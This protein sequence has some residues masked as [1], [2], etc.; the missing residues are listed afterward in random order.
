MSQP[1]ELRV[2]ASGGYVPGDLLLCG[3]KAVIAAIPLYALIR[4]LGADRSTFRGKEQLA[5]ILC[6][7]V[8]TLR[9]HA[10]ALES[11]GWLTREVWLDKNTRQNR[12]RWTVHERVHTGGGYSVSRWSRGPSSGAKGLSHEWEG[13]IAP[14]SA[15]HP[16]V[17]PPS[18]KNTNGQQPSADAL[19]DVWWSQWPHK[20]SKGQ[21]RKAYRAAVKKADPQTLYEAVTNQLPALRQAK[22]KGFCPHA[23]TWLNGER[24]EDEAPKAGGGFEDWNPRG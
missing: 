6:C 23:S 4:A 19:F 12:A 5:E 2:S 11:A 9:R 14:V 8:S 10:G 17:T 16:T 3:D 22:A 18:P 13:P 20:K 24:W 15:G 7:S 21:A 1:I